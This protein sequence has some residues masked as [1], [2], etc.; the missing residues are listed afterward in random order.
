MLNVNINYP[1]PVIRDY[2]ED[3]VTTVFE[4]KLSVS[5]DN[6]GYYITPQFSVNNHDI[7]KLLD[8]GYLSYAI[9]VQCVSTWF[10]KLFKVIDNQ[11]IRL[12]PRM[13]HERVEVIPCIIVKKAITAF[14]IVDFVEEYHDVS[15]SLKCGDVI[16][17][18]TKKYFDALYQND[19]IKDGSSI[20]TVKGSD[21]IKNIEYDFNSSIIEITLPIQQY[22]DYLDCGYNKAKYKSLNAIITIPVLVEAISIIR[23]DEINPEKQSGYGNYAW[24]K[25]I[26][27]NLKRYAE[28][29]ENRY[30]N[31]L[32]KSSSSSEILLGNNYMDALKY[33]RD[34]S[35]E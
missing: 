29:D 27:A 9:E 4:G 12:D 23:D 13:I 30:V 26:V 15:I 17:I 31:L 3:Y 7:T 21:R 11:T 20:V 6:D 25:T 10:R 32:N 19:I 22:E 35:N 16:A 18:G 33:M 24:Y 34:S 28:N 8:D 14:K 5:L 2:P 1:Y